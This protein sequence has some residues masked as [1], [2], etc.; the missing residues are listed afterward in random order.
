MKKKNKDTIGGIIV[1]SIFLI[2]IVGIGFGTF[3]ALSPKTHK[4]YSENN[5]PRKCDICGE[6]L[7]W[8]KVTVQLD[9]HLYKF[10]PKCYEANK[11]GTS[12]KWNIEWARKDLEER[13]KEKSRSYKAKIIK[14][15][16]DE[17]K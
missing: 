17:L 11:I 16:V 4:S 3:K 5:Y 6:E 12:I 2:I 8:D 15:L 1:L 14:K 9:Y 7:P 13:I 10:C